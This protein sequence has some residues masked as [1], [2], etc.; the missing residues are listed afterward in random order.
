MGSSFSPL[1]VPSFNCI[2]HQPYLMLLKLFP[3]Y[4]HD[5]LRP[6][7]SISPP[8]NSSSSE[9]ELQAEWSRKDK[10]MSE[11]RSKW[12][13]GDSDD[14]KTAYS[15]MIRLVVITSEESSSTHHTMNIDTYFEPKFD[16]IQSIYTTM[17]LYSI[18]RTA[19][20]LWAVFQ[21]NNTTD[22]YDVSNLNGSPPYW[23]RQ[24]KCCNS[25]PLRVSGCQLSKLGQSYRQS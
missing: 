25:E 24:W 2:V 16:I 11:S 12:H 20:Q 18:P 21:I 23:S 9:D 22:R 14:T 13:E 15:L 3:P 10:L 4:P 5:L 7:T 19:L 8:K 6:T 17:L 1:L